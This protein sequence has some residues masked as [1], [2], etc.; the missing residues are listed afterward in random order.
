M[1]LIGDKRN[2]LS[3]ATIESGARPVVWLV[4]YTQRNAAP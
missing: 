2:D 4:V 1:I 3:I